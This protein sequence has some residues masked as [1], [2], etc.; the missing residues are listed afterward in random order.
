MKRV[1]HVTLPWN[2]LEDPPL[3]RLLSGL[4]FQSRPEQVIPADLN[5]LLV[6]TA[7]HISEFSRRIGDE[8]TASAFDRHASELAAAVDELMWCS[9]SGCWHD[10]VLSSSTSLGGY[11]QA[12]AVRGGCLKDDRGGEDRIDSAQPPPAAAVSSI[13]SQEADHVMGEVPAGCATIPVW[14]AEQH[15]RTYA[16]NWL[17]LWCK[18]SA[19]GGSR[20]QAAVRGLLSSGLIDVVGQRCFSIM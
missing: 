8:P 2:I 14:S 3:N 13:N 9:E 6:M 4:L 19:L 17:P 12:A 7:R 20:T 15:R 11:L 10:L 1:H 5:A 18:C 16:S